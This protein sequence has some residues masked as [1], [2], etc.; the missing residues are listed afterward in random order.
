MIFIKKINFKIRILKRSDKDKLKD[1][2]L[3]LSENTLLNW[4]RFGY[5]I[6]ELKAKEIACEQVN[7]SS[8]K[9][10]GFVSI[11]N[12]KIVG[13]GY[14]RFF[15]DKPQKKYTTSL[16]IIISNKYQCMGLGTTMMEHLI[17]I[18]KKLEMKKI[19]LA[20]YSDNFDAYRFYKKFNFE[21]EGIFMYDEY[22]GNKPRHV[23]SMALFLDNS[24]IS[25]SKKRDDIISKLEKTSL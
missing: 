11:F 20:T 16:G 7:L 4:N 25:S 8:K 21:I 22:F 6:S 15:T 14:L 17:K 1:F 19:W 13:Y 23:I 10:L 3:S 2:L 5:K 9:E 18:A 12:D 24:I